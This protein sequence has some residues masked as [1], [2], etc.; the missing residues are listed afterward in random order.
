MSRP[1][2]R[3][4]IRALL[5]AGALF[6]LAIL[7]TSCGMV[8]PEPHTNEA[9]QV[10]WLYNV[11]LAMGAVVFFGVEGFI[12]YS[13]VRYR[14]RDDRLPTQVH[15]NNLVEVIW[16]AIPTVIVLILFGAQRLP[17]LARSLGRVGA[18]TGQ[19]VVDVAAEFSGWDGRLAT[20]LRDLVLRP[21]MLTREFLEGRRVRYISPLRLYLIASLVYF[22]LAAGAPDPGDASNGQVEAAA[23]ATA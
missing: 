13:I 21:G 9:K 20:S 3:P 12:V 4:R 14:R 23:P 22:L 18:A 2:A 7:A 19:L 1:T 17:D 10:F 11:V 8:P 15:G 16:T 5:R 6:A